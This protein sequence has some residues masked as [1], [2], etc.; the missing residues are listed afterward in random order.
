[1]TE[2]YCPREKKIVQIKDGKTIKMKNGRTAVR[3][4]CPDCGSKVYRIVK[5]TSIIDSLLGG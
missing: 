1:M 5:K 4:V 3:G 2:G